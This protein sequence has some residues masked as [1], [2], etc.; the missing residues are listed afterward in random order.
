MS[1]VPGRLAQRLGGTH[2]LDVNVLTS[3]ALVSD[4]VLVTRASAVNTSKLTP[5]ALFNSIALKRFAR[6]SVGSWRE[7]ALDLAGGNAIAALSATDETTSEL[8][9]A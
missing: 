2:P 9:L 6:G 8:S 7:E 3:S 1:G 4:L 5:E